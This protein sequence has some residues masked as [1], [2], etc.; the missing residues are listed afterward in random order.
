[1]GEGAPLNHGVRAG[2]KLIEELDDLL[3]R[4]YDV[5]EILLTIGMKYQAA[6]KNVKRANRLDLLLKLR[7][8]KKVDTDRLKHATGKSWW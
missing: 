7:E 1:M 3:P 2:T 5:G 6:E 4:G 8:W